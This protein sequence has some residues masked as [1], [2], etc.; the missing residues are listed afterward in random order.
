MTKFLDADNGEIPRARTDLKS[1]TEAK[2][3]R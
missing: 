2:T 3:Q 1:G